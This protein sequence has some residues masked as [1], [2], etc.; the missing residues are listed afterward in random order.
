MPSESNQIKTMTPIV[1]QAKHVPNL[2][3][4]VSAR[5][6]LRHSPAPLRL[7]IPQP[8]P[9]LAAAAATLLCNLAGVTVC[10]CSSV[11]QE[12]DVLSNKIISRPYLCCNYYR[13]SAWRLKNKITMLSTKEHATTAEQLGSMSLGASAERKDNDEIEPNVENAT[14]PTKLC[15]AC[16]KKS[17]ALMKCRNCMCVWYCDK[18]CQNRHWKEHKIEC[19]RIKKELDERG[20]KLDL[21]TEVDIGPTCIGKLPPREEC[22]ICM[23][24]L[25]IPARLQTYFPCCG[26]TICCGCDHQHL[27][28]IKER[29]K[30]EQKRQQVTCPFCRTSVPRSDEDYLVNLR[31]RVELN[32]P[33]ALCLMALHYGYGHYGLPVDQTKCIELL[34]EAADGLGD[35]E[36][37]YQLG[38]F[39]CFGK[40]G[41]EQ[42]EEESLRYTKKAAECGHLLARHN[43]GCTEN[44]NGDIVAAMPHWRLSASGGNKKSMGALIGR[45]ENGLLHHGDL[46][47]T[48][49][50]MYAARAEMRSKDRDQYLA[51]LKQTGEYQEELN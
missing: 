30:R 5:Q 23:Q 19:R 13:Y 25:P 29:A 40:M 33:D 45:F 48:L 37:Q 49:Q 8:G 7:V 3:R 43:L 46:A 31:K 21:G 44:E 6:K 27:M 2:D 50:A 39:H 34:R 47:E 28:K 20:G 42:N 12:R 4:Y 51:Y 38:D 15:S 36:A 1:L 41:L 22:P 17:D 10:V 9:H 14:T 26:K 35:P 24:V 16:G 11:R 32:D 18:E